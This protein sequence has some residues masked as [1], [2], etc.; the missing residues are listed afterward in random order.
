M[1]NL[2]VA[3]IQTD[4]AWDNKELNYKNLEEKISNIDKEVDLIVLPEMFNTGF[5]MSQ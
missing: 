2:K 3:I 5:I 1:S 4:I